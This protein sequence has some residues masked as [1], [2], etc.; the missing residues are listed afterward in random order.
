MACGRK[1]V[2]QSPTRS[3][4]SLTYPGPSSDI[5]CLCQV[6]TIVRTDGHHGPSASLAEC[7]CTIDSGS[8]HGARSGGVSISAVNLSDRS[9]QWCSFDEDSPGGP[10][11]RRSNVISK[12]R[13]REYPKL[14]GLR[15]LRKQRRSVTSL[16]LEHLLAPLLAILRAR[17]EKG[18]YFS[19]EVLDSKGIH[20]LAVVSRG[21]ADDCSGGHTKASTV[22]G[23]R[24]RSHR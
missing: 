23:G 6:D 15:L 19:P 13:I 14:E 3:R 18:V 7:R 20:D 17:G 1:G 21:I 12:G 9:L 10:R 22:D 16:R 4:C 2:R 8:T 5:A 11:C 24:R